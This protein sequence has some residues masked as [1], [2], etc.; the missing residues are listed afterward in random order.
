[1][2]ENRQTSAPKSL[3]EEQANKKVQK[4]NKVKIDRKRRR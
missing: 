1:M 2:K 4:K 3:V